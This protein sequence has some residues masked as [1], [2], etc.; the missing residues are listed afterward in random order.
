A[1]NKL[2]SH[3]EA[4]IACFQSMK[5]IY[6]I[7]LFIYSALRKSLLHPYIFQWWHRHLACGFAQARCLCHLKNF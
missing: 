7:P 4:L 2:T 3:F 1:V 5:L 6:L